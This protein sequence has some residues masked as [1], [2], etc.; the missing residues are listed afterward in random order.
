LTSSDLRF[1]RVRP[2][3]W[4]SV[5]LQGVQRQRHPG[6]IFKPFHKNV[7]LLCLFLDL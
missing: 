5:P 6:S 4:L 1:L 2:G 3:S 7:C